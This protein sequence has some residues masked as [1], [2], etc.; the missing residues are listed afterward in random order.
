MECRGNI[1]CEVVYIEQFKEQSMN[2]YI[3]WNEKDFINNRGFIKPC[4]SSGF[5]Y[6]TVLRSLLVFLTAPTQND[7]LLYHDCPAK[8]VL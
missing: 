5:V 1:F 6:A 4:E 7:D 2:L 3:H 8:N